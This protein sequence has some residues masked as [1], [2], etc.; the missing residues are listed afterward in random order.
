M[1]S[2]QSVNPDEAKKLII[3]AM[4]AGIPTM[5]HGQPGVGKSSVY[6]SIANQLQLSFI[7]VRL[8]QTDPIDLNG[9]LMRAGDRGEYMPMKMWPLEGDAIPTGYKGFMILLDEINSAPLLTQAAAYKVV[10]DKMIGMRKLHPMTVVAAAGNLMTDG[11]IV[12]RLSTAMQSRMLHLHMHVEPI[13]WS[14]WASAH[15]LAPEV[16]SFVNFMPDLLHDFKPDHDDFTFPCP[17]TW[18]FASK[19]VKKHG[20]K[21]VDLA[22]LAGT[23]GEGAAVEFQMYTEVYKQLP[24]MSQIITDP[25][26]TKLP[27]DPAAMTAIAGMIGAATDDKNIGQTIVYLDRMGIEFQTFAI[28][29]IIE[30]K[31][32]MVADKNIDNW[33]NINAQHFA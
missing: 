13:Q 28:R 10:H 33:L 3:K 8:S 19:L 11:A 27:Y 2:A 22:L 4:S 25:R 31:P 18:E 9:M 16:I 26:R 24:T 30:R 23:V 6:Q 15:Q 7:D 21:D 17:R 5:C 14:H 20:F 29:D 12:N 32:H 1:A